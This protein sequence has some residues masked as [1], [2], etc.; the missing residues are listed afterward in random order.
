MNL[1]FVN[2]INLQFVMIN[3]DLV[4]QLECNFK[5]IVSTEID[6]DKFRK[7]K[8]KLVALLTFNRLGYPSIDKI[9]EFI[10][11]GLDI[12]MVTNVEKMNI[13]MFICV[14]QPT[15]AT[16]AE[17]WINYFI[18]AGVNLDHCDIN[19]KSTREYLVKYQKPLQS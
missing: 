8:N 18:D 16:L 7:Y 1:K 14:W 17:D 5:K 13:I 12:N 4:D 15:F 6:S 9:Q 11:A 19:G 10:D 2:Y 3:K